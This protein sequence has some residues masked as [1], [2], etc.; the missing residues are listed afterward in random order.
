MGSPKKKAH[1]AS[2]H[3]PGTEMEPLI[4]PV[5]ERLGYLRPSRELLEFYRDK[6]SQFDGEQEQL[7][8][9]LEKYKSIIENQ[10]KLEGEVRQREG[11]IAELQNALSDMQVY[12]YQER[13]QSLRLHAENDRL[14][15]REL[16]DRKKIQHLL[17]L[18]DH[19]DGEITYFL[20]EPPHKVTV[21]QKHL[22]STEENL[23]LRPTKLRPAVTGKAREMRFK[24]AKF[25]DPGA[26]DTLEKYKNENQTLMLQVEA[27]QAQ[28]E[29]LTR[30]TKEQVQS[31]QD[32]RQIKGEEVQAERQRDEQRIAGLTNKLQQTQNLLYEST[33]DFLQ[34]K[35][36]TRAQEKI[37]MAE[38]DHLF[39]ELDA[40][41]ERLRKAGFGDFEAEHHQPTRR[42]P[43][44]VSLT[45]FGT[46]AT[47]N[48]VI[49]SWTAAPA[50]GTSSWTAAPIGVTQ[51]WTAGP[52]GVTPSWPADPTGVTPSWPAGPTGV[53]QS[54]TAGPTG[55]TPSWPADPTGVTPSWPA[56]STGVTQSWTAGPTGVTP[57]WTAGPTGVNPSRDAA[58]PSSVNP[59][60]VAAG[61]SGVNPSLGAAG[62]S[63]VN[64]SRGAAGPSGVNPSR[65][66]AGPSGV[67]PSHVAAGPSGVNP[68]LGA[69]D[70]SGVNP[71]HVAAGPSGV[72]PSLGAADPSGVNPSRVAAGPSG[73]N[74]SRVAA[75]PSGVN[76]SRVAAGPSGVNPSRV[77]AGP[78]G[79]NP[80]RGAA[81]PSGVNPSLG[82]AGP[83]GV[84]P[85]RGAAGPSGVNPSRGAAGPSGVNPSRGATGPTG[86]N[87]SRGA[88][89]STGVN[90]SRGATGPTR[91]TQLWNAAP[92]GV[93][94]SQGDAVAAPLTS[95]TTGVS[96]S[97]VAAT[98]TT[99]ISSSRA[100]T[101]T[102]IS[103][104]RFHMQPQPDLSQRHKEEIKSGQDHFKEAQRMA[105]MYREQCIALE[106]EL[107]QAREQGDAGR[108][109]YKERV[110]KTAK[111]LQA[112]TQRY[113]ALEKRRNLEVEGFKTDLKQLRHKL[114][115]VEK[116]LL[117][118]THNIGPNQDLA[119]L[120]EVRESNNR[121]K[122]VQNGLT[123]LKAK[124][125]GL[126]NELRFC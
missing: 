32:D 7:L 122:K 57:S 13:E 6:I 124:I 108:E 99:R 31:L 94:P 123:V 43:T 92:I 27:L 88:A 42:S 12:L 84:N 101:S 28:L 10:H 24:R 68:S 73:V 61:P 53:T 93:S 120:Q 118:V 65:G 45:H 11:E 77:A 91:V 52:T 2:L 71:S 95:A 104:T 29:E 26:C 97:R 83:S 100:P 106:T 9:M 126:E 55:V 125:Y 90:P 1:R 69:A 86:V 30:L 109:I 98:T 47:S 59:S 116:Q 115:D 111:R 16:E 103:S 107:A 3:S 40:C 78:S 114:K 5:N 89:G 75:G 8:Q 63:G 38:K 79:F 50:R 80:S 41:H 44:Q 112:M 46:A 54:W 49:P 35:F 48:G 25:A 85:S 4:P 113:E 15:I 102:G 36:D 17:S 105:E 39:G 23:N 66:A 87:P 110:S 34:L 22:E 70:P 117:Q 121:T 74:P 14:K 20:R 33:K 82:A 60:R 64:P 119:I 81:G 76:P 62:P 51:S 37:W 21:K 18:V 72:N 96:Q 58:G 67:N 19:D 56:G